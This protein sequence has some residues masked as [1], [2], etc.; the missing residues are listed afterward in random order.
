VD[1]NKRNELLEFL[2][3]L[4]DDKAD[5]EKRLKGLNEEIAGIEEELISDML[6]HEDASFNHKGITCSLVQKEYV[7]PEQERKDDLWTAM[8]ENGFEHLFTIN[9]QTLSGTIKELKANNDDRL[10]EWLDGLVKIAEK[11]GIRLSKGKRVK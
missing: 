10:P 3:E 6:E 7:S 9:S 1:A 2:I 5:L 11:P 4:R 8:K